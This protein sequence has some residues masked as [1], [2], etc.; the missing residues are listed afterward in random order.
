VIAPV[1]GAFL[2]DNVSTAA[3]GV[4]GAGLMGWLVLYS[5]Q[6]VLDV[7]DLECPEPVLEGAG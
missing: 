2:L 6:K 4:L 7:P 3:P 1:L 5:W